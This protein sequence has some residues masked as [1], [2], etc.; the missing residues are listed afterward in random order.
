M[1]GGWTTNSSRREISCRS[2]ASPSPRAG[3]HRGRAWHSSPRDVPEVTPVPND[4]R[5]VVADRD[6]GATAAGTDGAAM[7]AAEAVAVLHAARHENEV[8]ITTMGSA[9]DW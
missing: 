6:V 1:R 4:Q 8:V 7:P 3:P 5:T 2:C 9:R